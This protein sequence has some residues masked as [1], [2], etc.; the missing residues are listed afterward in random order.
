[1]FPSVPT[2]TDSKPRI[3]LFSTRYEIAL[4]RL[5]VIRFSARSTVKDWQRSSPTRYQL[6]ETHDHAN[7]ARPLHC[8]STR[9]GELITKSLQLQDFIHLCGNILQVFAAAATYLR[10]SPTVVLD[11]V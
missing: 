4:A 1:M 7:Q 8:F 11:I 6:S 9:R 3:S 10:G 2:E 5:F